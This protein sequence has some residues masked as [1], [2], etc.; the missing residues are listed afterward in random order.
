MDVSAR[1]TIKMSPTSGRG[2]TSF[3]T[4]ETIVFD[5]GYWCSKYKI[6]DSGESVRRISMLCA[7]PSRYAFRHA[8]IAFQIA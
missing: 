4:C 2:G 7:Q 8:W 3:A 6:A 1:I 5:S